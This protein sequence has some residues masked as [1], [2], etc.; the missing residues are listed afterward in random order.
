MDPNK[1]TNMQA[2]IKKAKEAAAAKAKAGNPP[3]PKAEKPAN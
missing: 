2:L 3:K 1:N